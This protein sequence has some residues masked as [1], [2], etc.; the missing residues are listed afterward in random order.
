MF[1]FKHDVATSTVDGDSKFAALETKRS[2]AQG[3]TRPDV[4]VAPAAS[5]PVALPH[6]QPNAVRYLT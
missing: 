5:V 6:V 4:E 3:E 2:V 1:L